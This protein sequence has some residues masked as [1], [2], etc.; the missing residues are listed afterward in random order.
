NIEY[1]APWF[2]EPMARSMPRPLY[3][4]LSEHAQQICRYIVSD[5]ELVGTV[6][7]DLGGTPKLLRTE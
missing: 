4:S 6:R 7:H 3:E 5:E 2:H 1:Y